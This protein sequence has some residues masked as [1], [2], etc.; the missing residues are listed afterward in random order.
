MVEKE[1]SGPPEGGTD[2]PDVDAGSAIGEHV[3]KSITSYGIFEKCIVRAEN[4]IFLHDSTENID[5][6]GRK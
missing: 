4:L 3:I 5:E 2:N 6:A 1:T